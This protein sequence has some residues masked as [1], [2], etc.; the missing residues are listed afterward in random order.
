M[1][2]TPDPPNEAPQSHPGPTSSSW[3]TILV[4]L[5]ILIGFGLTAYYGIRAVRS[6]R[7]MH[8][9][10]LRPGQT[11][12]SL[13]RPWMTVPY[14]ARAYRVPEEV[15]WQGLGIPERGNRAK[16][17]RALDR[18]YAGGKPGAILEKVKEIITE[19]QGAHPAIPALPVPTEPPGPD[20][21][22]RLSRSAF[23]AAE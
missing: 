20:Q 4:V 10:H 7:E 18:Q 6:Y 1:E 3:L 2:E 12:V 9:V 8:R 22:R 16:S 13:V 15:L 23:R 19:Y 17:L 21:A 5:L 14:I 11:D